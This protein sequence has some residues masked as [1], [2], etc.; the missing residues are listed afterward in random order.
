MSGSDPRKDWNSSFAGYRGHSKLHAAGRWVY[1]PYVYAWSIVLGI[2]LPFWFHGTSRWVACVLWYGALTLIGISWLAA[3]Q[4][5]KEQIR[6]PEPES[7]PMTDSDSVTWDGKNF[8]AV[9]MLLMNCR[10]EGDP[11]CRLPGGDMTRMEVRAG[12]AFDK[13][14]VPVQ[15]GDTISV[16]DGVIEVSYHGLRQRVED[17]PGGAEALRQAERKEG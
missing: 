7:E 4:Q 9:Q 3:R 13:D 11:A 1:M 2:G 10:D 17:M 14:W 16:T 15:V 12:T 8:A 5:R 6:E